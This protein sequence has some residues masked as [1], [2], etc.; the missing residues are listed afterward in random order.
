MVQVGKEYTVYDKIGWEKTLA[1][2]KANPLKPPIPPVRDGNAKT[3]YGM[4]DYITLEEINDFIIATRVSD[5][6][7]RK[8]TGFASEHPQVISA[9]ERVRTS[10]DINRGLKRNTLDRN[11]SYLARDRSVRHDYI[12]EGL[13]VSKIKAKYTLKKSMVYNIVGSKKAN[14]LKARHRINSMQA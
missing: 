1:A 2:F 6:A 14:R 3:L 13:S 11:F 10:K 7:A 5:G 12:Y 8:R 4:W 9:Y